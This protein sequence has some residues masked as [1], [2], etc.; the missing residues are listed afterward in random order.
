M[1]TKALAKAFAHVIGDDEID[2]DFGIAEQLIAHAQ[3][4]CK[5]RWAAWMDH[6]EEGLWNEYQ[7]FCGH[8][9]L[10][11]GE[12]KPEVDESDADLLLAEK[13]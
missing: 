10:A 12:T 2:A 4:H 6:R 11:R 8:C 7:F 1:D 13:E 9:G 3:E 5:H